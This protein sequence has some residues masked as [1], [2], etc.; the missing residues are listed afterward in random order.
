V[1]MNVLCMC[2]TVTRWVS[3]S[4]VVVYEMGSATSTE[5]Q[6]TSVVDIK[7]QSPT[8]LNKTLGLSLCLSVCLSLSV[9]IVVGN[10]V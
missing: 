4:D 10:T 1:Y 5:R 3:R 9:C 2:G 8:L 6:T 7:R